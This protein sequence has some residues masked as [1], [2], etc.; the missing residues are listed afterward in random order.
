MNFTGQPPMPRTFCTLAYVQS[1]DGTSKGLYVFGGMVNDEVSGEL[2]EYKLGPIDNNWK[3]INSENMPN[4]RY[5]HA[6]FSFSPSFNKM[7]ICGGTQAGVQPITMTS[8]HIMVIDNGPSWSSINISG[9]DPSML[10]SF[11][12]AA[13]TPANTSS[14]SSGVQMVFGFGKLVNGRNLGLAQQLQSFTLGC[15]RGE[16]TSSFLTDICRPCPY[17]TYSSSLGAIECISCPPDTNTSNSAAISSEACNVCVAEYCVH[18]HCRINA[19]GSAECTCS[20]LFSGHRCSDAKYLIVVSVV[21]A[22]VS[23]LIAGFLG[24]RLYHRYFERVQQEKQN[25]LRKI[26]SQIEEIRDALVLSPSAFSFTSDDVIANGS[27]FEV[28]VQCW[29]GLPIVICDSICLQLF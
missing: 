15:S 24:F 18:G 19:R 2:W 8:A 5:H 12:A 7:I 14:G 4:A 3:L 16:N 20:L 21:P 28:R 17:A 27:F 9:L 10:M 1:L 26:T 11:Q 25:L 6:A 22:L 23:L 29:V 13:Y